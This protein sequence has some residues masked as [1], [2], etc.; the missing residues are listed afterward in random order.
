MPCPP[1][2]TSAAGQ[3]GLP[4]EVD[5]VNVDPHA[6]KL[7]HAP[8]GELVV[9]ALWSDG[10][11]QLWAET[12]T[13]RPHSGD[14]PP[15]PPNTHP[16]SATPGELRARLG[17]SPDQSSDG[18][19][20]L[21]L[22]STSETDPLP[23]PH[24]AHALG[25]GARPTLDDPTFDADP[26]DL[27][28]EDEPEVPILADPAALPAAPIDPAEPAPV[29][30]PPPASTPT[31]LRVFR[32]DTLRVRPADAP[33]VLDAIEDL[34]GAAELRSSTAADLHVGDSVA[35]F[36]AAARLVRHLLAQQRFVPMLE[37]QASGSLS[38]VWLPW[39]G[40]EA[41]GTKFS[42]LL[43]A[44]P[45]AA[46][47]TTD[48]FAHDGTTILSD[49]LLRVGDALCRSVLTGENM[50]DAIEGRNPES[51]LHVT[52]LTGLLG[53]ES[54]IDARP[55]P[56][57]DLVKGVRR[58]IGSLDERAA[59]GAWRMLLKLA[60]P[61]DLGEVADFATPSEGVKWQLTLHLQSVQDPRVVLD[62]ED[63][64][65]LPPG[66]ANVEGHRVEA[67][68][69]LLLSELGRAS[70]MYKRL[71][72]TLEE[73]E[74]TDAKL[75]TSEAYK[76]L[77]E[78]R[79]LLI[80]QGFSVEAPAWWDSPT[81]RLGARLLVNSADIDLSAPA[82][83]EP[84][85]GG[86]GQSTGTQLGLSSLVSYRWQIA[87]GE[88]N[89]T[90]DQFER[91]AAQHSPLIRLNGRWVEVRPE[92]VKAA[93]RFIRENP[94]G[95]MEVGRALRLA[96]ASDARETGV[97][98]LGMDA[99]GWVAA[100]FGDPSKSEKM[101][102]IESPIGFHGTLRPYQLKGL[103]WLAFLDRIG[104]G[105][106]LADDMG[107]GKTVQLLA[108][109][110]HERGLAAGAAKPDPSSPNLAQP[111]QARPVQ[112][113]RP[114]LLVV[115]MSVV[116]NWVHEAH[117][118]TPSLRVLVH[119]G[120]E[121][122]IGDKLVEAS[123]IH[124]IVVTTYALA[125]RDREHLGKVNWMRV[126]L[127]EAQNIKN[128]G[129]KQTRA[130]HALPTPKRIALTG[131]PL[132]NR[133]LELWSIMDFL[134]PGYLGGAGEFRRSFA[135]PIERYHDK[136][137]AAQMRGLVQPFVL[138]RLK[139]DPA[140]ITDLPEKVESKEYCYLTPEQA[141]L[142]QTCVSDMLSAA[143]KA[144]GIQR[145]GLVLAGLIKLKQVCNHPAQFLKEYAVGGGSA[146]DAPPVGAHRS[147]KCQR[148]VE[149]LQEVVAAGDKALVFTQFRQMGHLLATMLRQTLDRDVL[150]L[151]GGTPAAKRQQLVADFQG[152]K[153]RGAR[154]SATGK[155]GPPVLI[156]SLKAGGVG[157]NLTA[158]NHVFHFDRWWNPAVEAQATD[159]AYRIGQT[160]TVQVHK[161]VCSGTLEE[162]IDQMI[163]AKTALAS[164][165][166]GS[167]EDWLTELDTTQL[168]D[169]LTLRKD[170]IGD[171]DQSPDAGDDEP[172]D[173]QTLSA[174]RAQLAMPG[175][176]M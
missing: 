49:F 113:T 1:R 98:I 37:Q 115:P 163:E 167:G 143:E 152:D 137:R 155:S 169:L 81:V 172:L 53:P 76:F 30:A 56:R 35:F 34:A 110:A 40:D 104:L 58:W 123:R 134:N 149:M 125:H 73:Q 43:A 2:A 71:E 166:V 170:A 19:L 122:L 109:L 68:Q 112:H 97:P 117:R 138:R 42:R 54:D 93:M 13:A 59:G 165:I 24:Q 85:P 25:D 18:S 133:L 15:S 64:W 16:R 173:A 99:T 11:L 126:V 83:E 69:E 5:L 175:G 80:E 75:S 70:R 119:H 27:G 158:A 118:F 174:M 127:D 65:A 121:R 159:R 150:F 160:R 52:W 148:I 57:A 7:P 140:V 51:D 142:Y 63:I 77:R 145:R 130:I 32:V 131:T 20:L 111:D 84:P 82:A 153:A 92:D 139:S 120:A 106:C 72:K 146:Q 90:L 66:P 44:M 101:P 129:A 94:G 47:C 9:H 116:S 124:D 135:I 48:A 10:A 12:S 6:P 87:V 55:G 96:Y 60:E 36:A 88:T 74:P 86:P 8:R 102:M 162:R 95:Q 4:V 23:S 3:A 31:E 41:T 17:L 67:P 128:P 151:H 14:T 161:F 176:E 38:G 78:I 147:G 107:L 136:H 164:E 171:E 26:I 46:R 61:I 156:L 144:E 168:R 132:E 157:L 28:H 154:A 91:L 21:R 22:P 141:S 105:A 108:L 100:V 103:S 33:M 79:P 45:P 50:L 29:I 89:L 62:A 114:T 39:L